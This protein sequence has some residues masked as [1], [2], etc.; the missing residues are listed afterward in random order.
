[1]KNSKL[2][3][4]TIA[5]IILDIKEFYL[6]GQKQVK[7]IAKMNGVE[8]TTVLPYIELVLKKRNPLIKIMEWKNP[9]SEDLKR[10]MECDQEKGVNPPDW[11]SLQKS[12]LFNQWKYPSI[13]AFDLYLMNK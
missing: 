7:D 8:G 4:A 9:V 10:A 6:T 3:E 5:Q 1:M 11:E 2:S 12:K 13:S